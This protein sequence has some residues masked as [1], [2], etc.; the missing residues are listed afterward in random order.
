MF[1]HHLRARGVITDSEVWSEVDKSVVEPLSCEYDKDA[2]EEVCGVIL[3]NSFQLR[4]VGPR[5][6]LVGLF[7][8]ASL[9][10]HDCVGNVRLVA[11]PDKGMTAYASVD[12]EK[13]SKNALTS[14]K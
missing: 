1:N 7:D 8:V 12:I 2:I 9:M 4:S 5:L 11:S 14:C 6:C 13:G 10:N 3:T